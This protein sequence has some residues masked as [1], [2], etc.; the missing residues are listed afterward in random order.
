MRKTVAALALIL[1]IAM[2]MSLFTGCNENKIIEGTNVTKAELD[3]EKIGDYGDLKLPIDKKNTEISV[4]CTTDVTT[5]NESVIIEELRKRT[6][7]NV[8]IIGVPTASIKEKASTLIAARDNMPDIF[9]GG[10]TIDEFNDFGKQGAFEA[11]NN[12]LDELP[13]LNEIFYKNAKKYGVDQK[14]KNL[15]S[16]DGDLYLFPIF[17]INRDV[18]HGML[19]RKDIFDKHGLKMWNNQEEFV[20]VLRKLKELYPDSYPM[21][22]KTGVAIFRDIG[23][24]WALNGSG[25][26]YDE[27]TGKWKMS[28]VD[29]KYREM[30]DL[31]KLLYDEGLIDPE[32]LTATQAA[33]TQKMTQA[34]KSFVTWDWIS[35]MDMFLEQAKDT[36]EGYDL[37]YGYPI[38]G[39]VI[40]LPKIS[41]GSAIKKSE[42]SMLAMKLCDY[43]ISDSGAQLMTM[44]IEGVTYNLNDKGF[45]EYVGYEGKTGISINELEE[46][47]GM[48]ISGLYKR[49]DR[50]STYYNF[51]E[52]EQEAQDLMLNKEGGG[53]WPEDPVLAFTKEEKEVIAQH[54]S[55]FGKAAEEFSTKYVLG[56][57][58]GDE[59]WENWLKKADS[60]GVNKIVEVY[61]KAQ[62]RYDAL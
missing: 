30:L 34:D 6:G 59:A 10:F 21:S 19:Y 52:R 43:L 45:A 51:T 9:S 22:S 39:K 5:N 29:P 61:N 27:P 53:F 25:P 33:W 15:M 47:Y 36:V 46:K 60:L 24:S 40:T 62:A 50:R 14:I 16:P 1:C 3:P 58:T 54:L 35:R 42:K 57:E 32:F 44:G 31:I 56:T 26:Y 11:L 55:S 17:D 41:G 7:L 2:S 8:Q 37:R 12:H 20:E 18:N 23:Y 38:G 28:G 48:F 49:F 4:L 13:N